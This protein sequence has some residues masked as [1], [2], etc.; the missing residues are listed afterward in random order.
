MT[1]TAS[2]RPPRPV[3]GPAREYH[4]PHFERAELPNGLRIVVA[5]ITRLPIATVLAVV[6][7]G[8]L[9]DEKRREGTAPLTAKLLLEGAGTL[10][11]AELTE[12]FERLGATIEAGADWD[13]SV[14]SMTATSQHLPEAFG[15]F[16]D[17]LRRPL[18]RPREVD[19]LKS[20]RLS[21]L[22]QLRAEPRG[23]ADEAFEAAVY[24]P[25][26][27]YAVSLGGSEK[28]VEA[29]G[30]TDISALYASR[31]TP[32]TT[33][34]VVTGD[35]AMSGVIELA[36]RHFGDW[37]GTAPRGAGRA[38][39]PARTTRAT[40]LVTR[41]ESQQSE[42]R[43]GHIGVPRTHDDY[44]DIVVMNAIL[45]GLFN[46]RINLNLREAHAYTYGAFTAFD[47]RRDAGPFVVSTA[48]RTDVTVEAITEIL[49][50]VERIRVEAVPEQELS[51]ATSYLDGVFPIRYETTAAVAAALANQIIYGLPDDYFDTYRSRIARVTADSVLA[52]ARKHLDPDRLQAVVVGDPSIA[53]KLRTLGFGDYIQKQGAAP[54]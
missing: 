35:V 41:P 19:R 44:F 21:D 53:E 9:W 24:H 14:V 29:I 51:L 42:L 34:L 12:R 25:D 49:A 1:A 46:S 36:R 26:S 40:H 30:P 27:R 16:A 31:Y 47:W 4:F 18:F 45:G 32:Y 50:E 28:T 20:E 48:V 33:T 10:D 38:D 7:A 37:T 3:P 8:A 5:P 43:L 13:A 22:L 6:D 39:R 2:A 23:L 17:V 15:L 52:A 11:G 54:R